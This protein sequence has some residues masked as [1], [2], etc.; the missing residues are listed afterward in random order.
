[1]TWEVNS[2]LNHVVMSVCA[3][4]VCTCGD[5]PQQPPLLLRLSLFLSFLT[6]HIPLSVI[7]PFQLSPPSLLF[8]LRVCV[9]RYYHVDARKCW[10]TE[11]MK[12][13]CNVREVFSSCMIIAVTHNCESPDSPDSHLAKITP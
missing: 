13:K 3:C 1:M 2:V 9:C 8:N 11:E 12:L 10:F 4:V 6:V 5:S 7:F